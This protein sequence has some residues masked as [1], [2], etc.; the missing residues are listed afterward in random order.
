MLRRIAI[1]ATWCLFPSAL[2]QAQSKTAAIVKVYA[3]AD[4]SAHI[5]DAN[6]NELVVPKEKDQVSISQA[7]IAKDQYEAGWLV[8]VP[9]AETTYPI[10][11][12]LIIYQPGKIKRFGDGMMIGKWLFLA[13]GNQVAFSSNTV[14]GDFAPHYELR[15]VQSGRLLGKWDGPLNDKAPRWAR[16]LKD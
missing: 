7:A 16:S 6:S 12:S 9:N 13:E 11:L 8:E 3:G 1:L 4:G 15:D 5:I 10:P 14:H 2:A